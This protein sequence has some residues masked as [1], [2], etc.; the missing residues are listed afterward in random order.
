M[1]KA[2]LQGDAEK[3]ERVLDT[4]VDV[5]ASAP[6][7]VPD[8]HLYAMVMDKINLSTYQS[9]IALLVRQGRIT[10]S[11]HLLRKAA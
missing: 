6:E 3:V 2:P 5:I 11:N 7:G 1:E 8:G 10:N 9:I 4:F